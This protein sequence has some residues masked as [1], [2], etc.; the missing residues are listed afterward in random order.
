MK[1]SSDAHA[2]LQIL[3]SRAV[4][5]GTVGEASINIPFIE[6]ADPYEGIKLTED[7]LDLVLKVRI[8]TEWE[9]AADV[10]SKVE[11]NFE[12]YDENKENDDANDAGE[13]ERPRGKSNSNKKSQ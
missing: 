6:I 10:E 11:T 7:A 3:I 8:T 1:S 13:E 12:E 5:Q 2:L 9:D 4:L